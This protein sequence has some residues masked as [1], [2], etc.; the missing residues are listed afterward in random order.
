MTDP[1]GVTARRLRGYREALAAAGIDADESRLVLGP[2]TIDGGRAALDRAWATG[3][4]ST[5]VLVMSDAMAIGAIDALRARG[6]E[7][8]GD[9]SVV[10]F[11]DIELA[12]YV[13]PPLTTV[14]QPIERKGEEA[15][16]LLLGMLAVSAG[17]RSLLGAHDSGPAA[18]EPEHRVLETRLVVRASTAPVHA[19]APVHAAAPVHAST[20]RAV[21]TPR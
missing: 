13:D 3:L 1:L 16:E 5:A 18:P 6:L 19:S 7:T 17:G 2:A 21:T 4:R 15:I 14:H 9:V 12:A 8:P 11:D 10:G 20:G